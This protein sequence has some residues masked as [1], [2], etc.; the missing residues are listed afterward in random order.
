MNTNTSLH[1][2]DTEPMHPP[3]D[4]EELATE[5][6]PLMAMAAGVPDL[7]ALGLSLAPLEAGEY[8]LMAETRKDGRVCPVPTRWLE[9]Y[10]VL[11]DAARGRPLPPPPLTGSGWASTSAAAKRARFLEHAEWAVRNGCI[12]PAYAFLQAL[13]AP[14]WYRGD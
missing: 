9:F 14:E 1:F 10:R 8:E 12:T 13:P 5:P 6:M 7:D 2:A 4:A 3:H 11:Q